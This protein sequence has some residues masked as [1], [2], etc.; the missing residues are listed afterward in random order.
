[1]YVGVTKNYVIFQLEK[2]LKV[3]SL[4]Y[5]ENLFFNFHDQIIQHVVEARLVSWA[6]DLHLEEP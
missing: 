4:T 5:D 6:C 3:S 2:I 1:M